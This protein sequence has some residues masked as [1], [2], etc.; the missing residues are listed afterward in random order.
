MFMPSA[1]G[2]QL[3][4]RDL[5]APCTADTFNFVLHQGK[6]THHMVS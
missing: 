1:C 3:Q 2:S 5:P 6:E 4:T